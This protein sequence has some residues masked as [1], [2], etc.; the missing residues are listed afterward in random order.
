MEAVG[1]D[2]SHL[3]G[4]A[5]HSRRVQDLHAGD[6]VAPDPGS[7]GPSSRS[8]ATVCHPS[9]SRTPV[10]GR[11]RTLVDGSENRTLGTRPHFC[12]NSTPGGGQCLWLLSLTSVKRLWRPGS[13]HRDPRRL[14]HGPTATGRTR[15]LSTSLP[16]TLTPGE[17]TPSLRPYRRGHRWPPSTPEGYRDARLVPVSARGGRSGAAPRHTYNHSLAGNGRR[18]CYSDSTTPAIPV[19]PPSSG[20]GAAIA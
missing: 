13:C 8:P 16:R 11:G 1:T 18:V 17:R 7:S 10:R 12:L 5:F 9:R 6:E 3:V 15:E 20:E 14:V 4:G 19:V 2:D